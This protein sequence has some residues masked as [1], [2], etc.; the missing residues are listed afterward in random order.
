MARYQDAT[1]IVRR[2]TTAID[3]TTSCTWVVPAG[4]TRARFEVWGAG[5]GGGAHCCCD[6]YRNSYGGAG[7]G[8]SSV[9]ISVSPGASYVACAGYGGMVTA[10]GSCTLHWCCQGG[11]GGTS[12]VQGTGLSGF[13]ATGGDPGNNYCYNHCGCG[14]GTVGCGY[15]GTITACGNVGTIG[16]QDSGVNYVFGFGGGAPFTGAAQIFTADNCCRCMIGTFGVFPGGGGAGALANACC[17]C[18]QAGTGANGL[19]RISY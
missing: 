16:G 11:T 8:Y 9:I 18:H 3:V 6:C 19:V 12:Y 1:T 10:V 2:G 7:G 5:G 14:T 4:I 15:G 17:C 13:C